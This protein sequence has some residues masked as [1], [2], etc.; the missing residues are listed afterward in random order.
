MMYIMLKYKNS[1]CLLF[2]NWFHFV[3]RFNEW[4]SYDDEWY[5]QWKYSG[6]AWIADT[7]RL[8]EVYWLL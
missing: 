3:E 4:L 1:W 6:Y 5:N 2:Y 8:A 7:D